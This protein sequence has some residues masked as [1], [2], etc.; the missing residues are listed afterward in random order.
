[1]V[2]IL[3]FWIFSFKVCNTAWIMPIFF[4]IFFNQLILGGFKMEYTVN[5]EDVFF[6]VFSVIYVCLNARPLRKSV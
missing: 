4:E 1:M 6:H 2:F 3:V 5:L